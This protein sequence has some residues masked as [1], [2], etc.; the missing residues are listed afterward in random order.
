MDRTQNSLLFV[1][2][3]SIKRK[4][5]TYICFPVFPSTILIMPIFGSGYVIIMY[6]IFVLFL[7]E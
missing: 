5:H 7:D 1:L 2:V 4:I 6:W 3:D